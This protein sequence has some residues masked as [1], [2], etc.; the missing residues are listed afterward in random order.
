MSTLRV[1]TMHIADERTT[2]AEQRMLCGRKAYTGQVVYASEVNDPQYS[3]L[4]HNIC[5]NCLRRF[6]ESPHICSCG[7]PSAGP[8]AHEHDR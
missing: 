7:F 4:R 3:D 1:S 2:G 5:K 8:G 6:D